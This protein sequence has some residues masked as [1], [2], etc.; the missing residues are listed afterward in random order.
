MAE[1]CAGLLDHLGVEAAHV[2]GASQGGM[3]AQT[4]AIRHPERVLSLASIMSTTG[5]RARRA[6]ASG[7]AAGADATPPADRDG[8]AE[9]V[10]G[11]WRV[12]GSPGFDPD[13]EAL[14]ARAAAVYD[15]GIHPDGTA[16]QLVAI[17][18]S[19]DRTEALRRLDVPTV[20]IHGTDD[21][22]IDVSGGEATA[23]AIPG[24]RLELIPGM[25]HD[26]PR[27]LWPRFVDLIVGERRPGS[28]LSTRS[29]SAERAGVKTAGETPA[30]GL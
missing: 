1:D 12:I 30:P 15:R 2:V 17:L 20:V 24:A 21:P 6:A 22:L 29:R 18:A 25:G 11:T 14:R 4:L 3:I 26:L 28:L 13:E 27:Q 5:D 8:F 7:G 23:A 9:F 16:R 19:G 10:V